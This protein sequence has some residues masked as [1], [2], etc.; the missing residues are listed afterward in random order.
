[1]GPNRV[2]WPG[3]RAQLSPRR[4]SRSTSV[5]H[6]RLRPRVPHKAA[7]AWVATASQ[8]L[9]SLLLSSACPQPHPCPRH[10]GIAFS[11]RFFPLKRLTAQESSL[12]N[13]CL[14][15]FQVTSP[16]PRAQPPAR[17]P[18]NPYLLST[19]G[20]H[21]FRGPS[22]LASHLHRRSPGSRPSEVLHV[23]SAC[24]ALLK[25]ASPRPAPLPA[26]PS[27]PQPPAP[28]PL[29]RPSL[30][31]RTC[32]AGR[33]DPFQ[34]ASWTQ[35]HWQG[36]LPRAGL[37]RPAGSPGHVDLTREAGLGG[38]WEEALMRGLCLLPGGGGG[39]GFARGLGHVCAPALV[40][41]FGLTSHHVGDGVAARKAHLRGA[42]ALVPALPLRRA[43]CPFRGLCLGSKRE[44]Q[45]GFEGSLQPKDWEG[46]LMELPGLDRSGPW[47]LCFQAGLQAWLRVISSQ[48][49]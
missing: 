49:T 31:G 2:L 18:P 43:T 16:D 27:S 47:S 15:P 45:R 38:G 7:R 3:P 33:L 13:T 46:P 14:C 40:G 23:A 44:E 35:T 25:A 9:R 42:S 21:G 5:S 41:D 30:G 1:M 28:P 39:V 24:P 20:K 26:R 17:L 34:G 29:S 6:R 11:C 12:G 4:D 48:R 10:R 36:D 32:F 37:D 19:R 22:F 8:G